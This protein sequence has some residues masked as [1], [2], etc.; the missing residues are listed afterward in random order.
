MKIATF[1]NGHIDR[2][3]GK[4]DVTAAWAIIHNSVVL[5]SGHSLD[6]AKA[7]KNAEGRLQE[8]CIFRCD[9]PLRCAKGTGAYLTRAQNAAAKAH[10]AARLAY[11]RSQVTIEIV[12][13]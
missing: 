2:Y 6:A 3:H 12:S 5:L 4:R 7:R 9:D 13:C 1:S 10:N 8:V 11:I